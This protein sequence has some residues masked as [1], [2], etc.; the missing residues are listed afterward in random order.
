MTDK[1]KFV[2]APGGAIVDRRGRE[3]ARVSVESMNVADSVRVMRVVLD[4][5]NADAT[6]AEKTITL[7]FVPTKGV[8]M[9]WL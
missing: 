3:V 1:P 6:D 4:A 7:T 2:E 5:L 9:Y 8:T